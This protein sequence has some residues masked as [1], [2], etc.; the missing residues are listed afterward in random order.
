MMNI[1]RLRLIDKII[2]DELIFD[3]LGTDTCFAITEHVTKEDNY[4]VEFLDNLRNQYSRPYKKLLVTTLYPR[5]YTI[6]D[7]F[8]VHKL[9]LNSVKG[10]IGCLI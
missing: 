7:S 5:Y 8:I 6:Y 10:T 2:D 9:I 3:F 4:N 1:F